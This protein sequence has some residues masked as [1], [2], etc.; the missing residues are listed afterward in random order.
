MRQILLSLSLLCLTLLTVNPCLTAEDVNSGITQQEYYRLLQKGSDLY[1]SGDYKA[2]LAVFLQIVKAVPDDARC[3]YAAACCAALIGDKGNALNYLE[4]AFENGFIDFAYVLKDP[5][6]ESI[7]NT[8]KFKGLMASKRKFYKIA[9]DKRVEKTKTYYGQYYKV[10]VYPKDRVIFV[11][12]VPEERYQRLM[13]IIHRVN[14][15]HSSYLFRNQPEIFNL[16]LCPSSKDE[17]NKHFPPMNY[18]GVFMPDSKLLFVDLNVGEGTLVHEYTHALHFADQEALGQEHPLWII[19]GF[20]TLYENSAPRGGAQL[21]PKM[22]FRLM[23]MYNVLDTPY[24][25]PLRKVMNFNPQQYMA[26]AGFCYAA[27]QLIMNYLY[28]TG[29]LL[30]F[31]THF[32][33]NFD[34]DPTGIFSLEQV[35]GKTLD[36]FEKTWKEFVKSEGRGIFE[37]KVSLGIKLTMAALN[38][39]VFEVDEDSPAAKAGIVANDVLLTYNGNPLSSSVDLTKCLSREKPGNTATIVLQRGND[40]VTV[41]V[42]YP[43]EEMKAGTG[44]MGLAVGANGGSGVIV[45]N[46]V[47]ESPADKAGIK[48]GDIIVEVDDEQVN[49]PDEFTA[50]LADKFPGNS[51]KVVVKRDG[52]PMN[53]RVKLASRPKLAPGVNPGL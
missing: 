17:Y 23:T 34:T 38:C 28:R 27:S 25:I 37:I 51:V 40:K 49:S 48:A 4:K 7:R 18:L 43:K 31:Y 3:W 44:Y 30:K 14:L 15:N 33:D 1:D 24:Y 47:N 8:G 41:K 32:T 52:K 50:A 16:V 6:L 5:D 9:N 35:T 22:G 42:E 36:E 45:G 26:N 20:S 11:S 12:D 13:D 19:E 21:Y 39:L 10:N 2:A 29:R 46:V 53:M